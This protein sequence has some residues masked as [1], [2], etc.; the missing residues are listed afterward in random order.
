MQALAFNSVTRI[1]RFRELVGM[2]VAR[3]LKVRYKRSV[4][5]MFWS[6]LNPLLQMAVYSFVFSTIMKV[7][8]PAYPLFLLSG[9]LPW[10]LFSTAVGMSAGCLIANASL[11]R[12]VAVPQAVYPL[13]LVGSKLVDLLLSLIPLTLMALYFG[14]PPS[15]SWLYLPVAIVFI[16]LFTTGVSLAISSLTV[17]FRD[18]KHLIDIFLQIW[19]Y[20]T[21]IIY[22]YDALSRI[23]NR[24][25]SLGLRAN[26][27]TPIVRCFQLCLYDGRFPDVATTGAAALSAVAALALGLTLFVGAESRHIHYL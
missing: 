11:I 7:G 5:G 21:P 26:P 19:F 18:V 4:L 1:M 6:L 15:V 17:F 13:A 2:L 14:R 23:G 24:W 20:L 3:D 8:T 12:K 16:L 10:A 27:I 9:L 22:T 25:V